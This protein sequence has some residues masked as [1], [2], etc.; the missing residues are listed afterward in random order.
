L[1]AAPLPAAL[2]K[3]Q[4]RRGGHHGG[5]AFVPN[6]CRASPPRHRLVVEP[7]GEAGWKYASPLHPVCGQDAQSNEQ[8]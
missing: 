7:V 6:P 2:H 4:S 8:A 3:E 5:F 1:N